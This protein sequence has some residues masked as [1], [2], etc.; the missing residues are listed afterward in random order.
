MKALNKTPYWVLSLFLC[1]TCCGQEMDK[2]VSFFKGTEAFELAKAIELSDL[3]TIETLV[4][5]DSTLLEVTN[6]ISGS[7]VLVLCL[8]VEQ[9]GSFEK[10]LDLGAN[11]NFINPFT[12]KSVLIES[13]KFYEKPEPYTID[14]R[15]TELLLEHGA[16]PKY[17][18]EKDFTDENGHYQNAT[19]PLIKA[20][21]LDLEL[22]KLLISYG[23][24]PYKKLEEDQSTA[25]TSAFTG[26]KNKFNIIDYFIDS[27]KVDVHQPMKEWSNSD[28][29]YIQDYVKKYM[30]YKKESEGYTDRK[31]LVEKLEDMG[32]DFK[33]YDYKL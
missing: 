9:Y 10:L 6:P 14:K 4:K 33:N 15:Y 2:N 30:S 24:D 32:V 18:I 12:K 7:N 1:L 28:F 3:E 13:I 20:S 31:R 22:V 23:A 27:L 21:R 16:D 17:T 29:L 25:F 5:K 11:P 26:Y 8:Y 19:S